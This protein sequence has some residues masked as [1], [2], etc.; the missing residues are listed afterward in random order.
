MSKNLFTVEK[1]MSTDGNADTMSTTISI[2]EDVWGL[3]D[4]YL[5]LLEKNEVRQ[6]YGEDKYWASQEEKKHV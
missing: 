5:I 6:Q 1:T 4:R 3:V 2:S